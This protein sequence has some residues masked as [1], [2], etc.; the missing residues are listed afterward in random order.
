MPSRTISSATF[1]PP[2]PSMPPPFSFRFLPSYFLNR[3]VA[4]EVFEFSNNPFH[5]SYGQPRSADDLLQAL[6]GQRV[7]PPIYSEKDDILPSPPLGGGAGGESSSVRMREK[8]EKQ[9]ISPAAKF[10][11]SLL[12]FKEGSAAFK[13]LCSREHIGDNFEYDVASI[14]FTSP[15]SPP[16]LFLGSIGE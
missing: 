1:P 9:M 6:A 12:K 3:I 8:L 2:S 14:N 11:R 16:L 5:N 4:L 15:A 13:D 7:I 10:L